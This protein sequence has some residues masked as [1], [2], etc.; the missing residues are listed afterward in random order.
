MNIAG[1]MS[2]VLAVVA[3][4]VDQSGFCPIRGCYESCKEE[5][6]FYWDFLKLREMSVGGGF[7]NFTPNPTPVAVGA[8]L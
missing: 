4:G 3:R 6:S 5:P 1:A 2:W 8:A 7:Q